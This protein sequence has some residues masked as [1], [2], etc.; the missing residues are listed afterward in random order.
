MP[1][2]WLSSF[3]PPGWPGCRGT[4]KPGLAP[5]NVPVQGGIGSFSSEV[6]SQPLPRLR[7]ARSSGIALRP[8]CGRGGHSTW[9]VGVELLPPPPPVCFLPPYPELSPQKP[10]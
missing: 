4:R 6:W 3:P 7:H 5:P 8:H 1:R 9:W 2:P 10:S